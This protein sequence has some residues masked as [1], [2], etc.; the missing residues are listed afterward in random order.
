M[1]TTYGSTLHRHG[2]QGLDIASWT[3]ILLQETKTIMR[4]T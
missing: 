1:V 3:S 2:A 4:R